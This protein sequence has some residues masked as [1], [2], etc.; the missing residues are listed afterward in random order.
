[1]SGNAHGPNGYP[2]RLFVGH[3]SSSLSSN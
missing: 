2:L 1:M 3:S